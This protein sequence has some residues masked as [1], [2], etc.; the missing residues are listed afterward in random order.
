MHRCAM[1]VLAIS[2]C[3]I[4]RR[5]SNPLH[6]HTNP[7]PPATDGSTNTASVTLDASVDGTARV[8]PPPPERVVQIAVG[9][10]AACVRMEGGAVSCFGDPESVE[11]GSVRPSRS[12]ALVALDIAGRVR[13]LRS[14]GSHFCV[15][16]N[17]NAVSCW[18]DNHALACGIDNQRDVRTPA[19][20]GGLRGIDLSLSSSG[21]CVLTQ[22]N[23]ISCWG[24]VPT[25]YDRNLG[26]ASLPNTIAGTDSATRVVFPNL[27]LCFEQSAGRLRCVPRSSRVEA[28]LQSWLSAQRQ[29]TGGSPTIGVEAICSVSRNQVN[30]V[31]VSGDSRAMPMPN[32]FTAD[33]YGLTTCGLSDSLLRCEH[34]DS[35]S[36]F[37]VEGATLLSV[38]SGVA[39]VWGERI[40]LRCHEL[41][42]STWLSAAC[43]SLQT[44]P[45]TFSI[46]R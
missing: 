21:G 29:Q 28:T 34:P 41:R 7:F 35:V 46:L 12:C 44:Q 43:S 14:G 6:V 17:D 38:G 36:Q 10:R 19:P 31:Y 37:P 11:I 9:T 15:L 18:G 13:Q 39:C 25:T 30:T 42:P 26:E 16:T 33:C 2:G 32:V 8:L 24:A 1:I 40:G 45:H 22:W 4:G 5:Y 27:P 20:L 23:D 3:A